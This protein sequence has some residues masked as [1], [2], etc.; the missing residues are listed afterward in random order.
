VIHRL[1]YKA[2][3]VAIQLVGADTLRMSFPLQPIVTALDTVS[4]I[5]ERM[6]ARISEFELRRKAGIGH[7][8]TA[9]Q[10]DKLNAVYFADVLRT[11]LSVSIVT[12]GDGSQRAVNMRGMTNLMSSGPCAFQFFVDDVLLPGRPNLD[13]L[14]AP[15]QIAG[16]EIYSGPATIPLQYKT[17]AGGSC[18]VILVWTKDGS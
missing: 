11:Q 3:S 1:G 13:D 6:T 14:P 17:T 7:F 5:G 8:V 18:G 15:S 12:G 9:E 2:M 16:V 4:V 10:I